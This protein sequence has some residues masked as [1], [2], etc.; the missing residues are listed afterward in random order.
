MS[1]IQYA[2]EAAITFRQSGLSYIYLKLVF[3]QLFMAVLGLRCC[4][5][6]F[7]DCSKQGL[8]FIVVANFSWQCLLLWSTGSRA[9]VL[10]Q[11]CPGLV[12]W[13]PVGSSRTRGQAG[14][15]CTT[16]QTQL[17]IFNH[18]MVS[19]YIACPVIFFKLQGEQKVFTQSCLKGVCVCVC[20]YLPTR[21][22]T[23]Q[24]R[25][26]D[27]KVWLMKV[28]FITLIGKNTMG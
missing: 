2:V 22:H 16:R 18:C 14:I 19:T 21:T 5:R 23:S 4:M 25:L 24:E 7:S 17:C 1:C 28:I 10:Q 13:L 15:L 27:S 3:M 26:A 12:A 20:V 8:F 9:Q 6:A 11:L